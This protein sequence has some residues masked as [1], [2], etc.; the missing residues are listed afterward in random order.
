MVESEELTDVER[1]LL[2]DVHAPHT[3]EKALRLL[4]AHAADR[5]ELVAQLESAQRETSAFE[6]ACAN[7]ERVYDELSDKRRALVAQVAELTRERDE[8]RDVARRFESALINERSKI[9]RALE[10]CEP[11]AGRLAPIV[12]ALRGEVP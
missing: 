4:D 6:A 11:Y 7:G 2:L 1:G 3:A 9:R 12:A 10:L 8:A 5:A